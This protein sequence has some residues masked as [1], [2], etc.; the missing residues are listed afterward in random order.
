VR[1]AFAL[2]RSGLALTA[3]ERRRC[4]DAVGEPARKVEEGMSEQAAA[5]PRSRFVG[6]GVL[7]LALLTAVGAATYLLVTGGDAAPKTPLIA[8]SS[9][10]YPNTGVLDPNRPNEGEA[11]PNFA[12]ADARDTTKVRKLSDF[13]GQAVV[14]NWYASWCG[15]CT[16]EIPEFQQA[17]DTLGS[18]VVF[19]GIDYEESPADATSILGDLKATYPAVLD[20]SGVVAD[21]YRV[22][23]GGGGLPTTFFV[24][25]DGILRGQ[26]TGR[27]TA[28]K[29]VENLAKAGVSYTAP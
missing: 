24:D 28:D 10:I 18:Q 13:K 15:P 6:Y 12:L 27:V 8:S 26:V 7:A 5:K 21:H 22:G 11:A 16:T 19:L 3:H 25:K 17:Q 4:Y 23:Q 20:P 1:S 14:L 2:H 9:P 29:L